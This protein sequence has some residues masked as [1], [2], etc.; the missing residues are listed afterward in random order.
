M[1]LL[2]LTRIASSLPLRT[3]AVT[4]EVIGCRIEYHCHIRKVKP[5][6]R[7]RGDSGLTTRRVVSGYR[8]SG[9]TWRNS[10]EGTPSW[11]KSSRSSLELVKLLPTSLADVSFS[12]RNAKP[13]M[14]VPDIL[15]AF[16]LTS[17]DTDKEAHLR[18][19]NCDE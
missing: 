8:G 10:G 6:R 1:Y 12:L 11:D 19:C 17:M 14:I 7:R 15:E 3:M 9:S 18:H 16:I 13:E 2:A 4:T 5:W